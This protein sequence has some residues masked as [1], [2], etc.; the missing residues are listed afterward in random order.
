MP[1]PLAPAALPVLLALTPLPSDVYVPY[2]APTLRPGLSSVDSLVDSATVET[3]DPIGRA[4][5]I[6][7]KMPRQ[8]NGSYGSFQGGKP[9]PVV[10]AVTAATPVGQMVVIEGRI[11]IAGT[12]SP[13]Q[14][15][16][17]AKSDQLDLLV[18]GDA[19]GADLDP[20]GA[21]QGVQGLSLSGWN[22]DRLTAMGGRL[23][24]VAVPGSAPAA[25]GP[26]AGGGLIRGLW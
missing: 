15:N 5:L 8:W 26:A 19:S 21:F 25:A 24:L 13:V 6:A 1:L 7:A 18:L 2:V 23:Q 12:E 3:F 20:G 22:G 4:G 14:G 10:L 11:T 16:L 17:N 9:V